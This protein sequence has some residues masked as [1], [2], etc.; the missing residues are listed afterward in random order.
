LVAFP[1]ETVYG[2]G[3]DAFDQRAVARIFEVKDRPSFDPLIVHVDSLAM[4]S[5]LI[6]T[7][8]DAAHRLAEAFWPGPLT[9]VLPKK[10]SVPDIVTAGLPTA[11][12]RVPDHPVALGLIREFGGPIA[13]PSANPFG[14]VSPTSAAHVRRDLG[15]KMDFILDGGDCAVGVES[16]IVSLGPEGPV[17]LRPGGLALEEIEAVVGKVKTVVPGEGRPLSPGRLAGHYAIKTP[18]YLSGGAVPVPEGGRKGYIGLTIP[19]DPS[20]YE[21]I[22]VLSAD[23]DLREAAA[24]LFSAMRDLDGA[25]LDAIV[26]GP[27]PE[28]GLGRAINDRLRKA[29]KKQVRSEE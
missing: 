29:S 1:T 14:R 11:A 26:A 4:A 13:A 12:L 5:S 3:A 2:L 18:F 9:L 10:P 25:R 20:E 8:P 6:T 22:E 17:L 28:E 21:R 15:D 19:E 27:V 23:G 24:R 7:L 16:T